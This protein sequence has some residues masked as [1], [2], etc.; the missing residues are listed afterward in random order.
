MK[1]RMRRVLIGLSVALT[2]LF[3]LTG[4]ALGKGELGAKEARNLIRRV[5]GSD[6]ASSAV[7]IRTIT[8]TGTGEA[9]AVA[10]I[11]TAF[12]FE[13]DDNDRWRIAE[14]RTGDNC[15]EDLQLFARAAGGDA[16][17]GAPAETSMERTG[18]RL[19]MRRLRARCWRVLSA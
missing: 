8:S 16:S 11:E 13:Q 9:V 6:L 5:L 17:T 18:G 10:Q 15:W 4:R 14:I 2:S 12:R 3:P 1:R 7:R 19:S